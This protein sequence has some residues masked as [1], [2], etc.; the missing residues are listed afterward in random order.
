MVAASKSR[1][2]AAG[3]TTSRRPGRPRNRPMPPGTS[4]KEQILDAA[5]ALFEKQGFSATTTRQIADAAGLEQGSMFHYFPRKKD[6]L[7]TLLDKTLLPALEHAAWLDD[8]DLPAS[9]KLYLLS[10]R[11][12]FTFC[13]GPH[14]L[15]A[16]LNLPEAKLPDFDSFWEEEKKLRAAYRRYIDAGLSDGS[17]DGISPDLAMEM[18]FAMVDSSIKWFQRGRDDA[19]EAATGVAS[20]VLR[21]LLSDR[22]AIAGTVARASQHL[23]DAPNSEPAEGN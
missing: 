6:I 18:V 20:S 9:E 22:E 4:P 5:A 2:S 3:R 16:L 14:N 17:F 11:D 8:V 23:A 10:Y 7:A 12:T 1:G 19:S 13:S 21:L 15:G